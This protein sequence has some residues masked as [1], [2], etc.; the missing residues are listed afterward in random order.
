M[1]FMAGLRPHLHL[2]KILAWRPSLWGEDFTLYITAV[3]DCYTVMLLKSYWNGNKIFKH[4]SPIKGKLFW[5]S[6]LMLT[7][8]SVRSL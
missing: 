4:L 1:Y 7:G 3:V 2:L 5:I 6:P 8:D